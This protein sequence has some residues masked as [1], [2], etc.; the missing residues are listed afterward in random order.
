M[1]WYGPA[2][3]YDSVFVYDDCG[4]LI[5]EEVPEYWIQ[6]PVTIIEVGGSYYLASP[7]STH[8]IVVQVVI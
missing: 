5:L 8:L 3:M 4:F 1:Y 2:F 7:Y 6:G